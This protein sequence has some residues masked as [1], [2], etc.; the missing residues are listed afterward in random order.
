MTHGI[1]PSDLDSATIALTNLKIELD[2]ER[3]ARLIA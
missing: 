1:V 2:Q 3:S